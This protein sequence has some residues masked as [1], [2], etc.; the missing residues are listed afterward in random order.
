MANRNSLILAIFIILESVLTSGCEKQ[1]EER[2]FSETSP[3]T[4]LTSKEGVKA[5]LYAA[6][7]NSSL[8]I[9]NRGLYPKTME[10]WTADIEWSS[11]GAVNS[12]FVQLN[13]FTFDASFSW[14]KDYM[15]NVAFSAIRD[16][17][18]VIDNQ[19]SI[20]DD[21]RSLFVAEARF[22]RAKTYMQLY[23]WF[24]PV[25]IRKSSNDELELPR[26]S[27]EEIKLFIEQELV[28]VINALPDPGK[29]ELYGRANKGAA[30]GLLCKFYLNT[31]QWQKAVSVSGDIMQLGYYSL[32]PNYADMFKV[33]NDGNKEMIWSDQCIVY[34]D[35]GCQIMNGWFPPGISYDPISGFQWSS[36]MANFA[37]QYRLK[38][39]FFNS[40]ESGDVRKES[41][42]TSYIN[43]QGSTINLLNAD[44]T[45]SFKHFPDGNA[46][47][48]DHGNDWPIVRYADI[49]LSRAEA[50]NEIHG[51]TQESIDLINLVRKRAKLGDI[52]LSNFTTTGMLRDHILKERGW[53]FYDENKRREDLIRHDKFI[54]YALAR[55]AINAKP[56]HTRFPIPQSEI[57]ANRNCEQNPGY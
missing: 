12:G 6:Y 7:A 38:D 49:L 19:E 39:S 29:E 8:Y 34:N 30:M 35:R 33:E 32:F 13:L 27:D 37:V 15:W 52:L 4:I 31:K 54:E 48:N 47:G 14:F 56:Y 5:V 11:G 41:I 28:D 42:L 43:L 55:G 3:N 26:A 40:F 53:E 44:N 50:L 16:V 22:I 23:S 57:D 25:M 20:P 24:G 45:R 18:V 36:T 21:V 51:P 9:G 17:N 1:L 10:E 46:I 2:P